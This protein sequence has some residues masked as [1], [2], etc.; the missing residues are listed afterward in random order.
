M[1][2]RSPFILLVLTLIIVLVR[3][4]GP[5]DLDLDIP[6]LPDL[7]D[8]PG[9]STPTPTAR[10]ITP[11]EANA[12]IP[13]GT[14]ERAELDRVI[15]GDTL[16]VRLPGGEVKRVRLIG[17]DTPER[18]KPFFREATDVH[19]GLLGAGSLSLYKDVSETD[20]FGRLLRYVRAGEVFVNYE[21]VA[22]GYAQAVTFPP[23]VACSETFRQTETAAREAGRGLWQEGQE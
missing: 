20:R 7:P 10:P 16:D 22:G 17:V 21:L 15:D 4:Y 14:A 11:A 6:G 3:L 9:L 23:D 19:T 5:G 2:K 8:L 1:K 12:C 13:S 18:G